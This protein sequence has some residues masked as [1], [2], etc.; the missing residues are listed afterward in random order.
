MKFIIVLLLVA[1]VAYA[2]DGEINGSIMT[3][4]GIYRII[5]TITPASG[6]N[7]L[8]IVEDVAALEN[9]EK[10][11]E[12]LASLLMSA[13]EETLLLKE[14][15]KLLDTAKGQIAEAM[16]GFELRQ[17]LL[18]EMKQ[19]KSEELKHAQAQANK[20]LLP[21]WM[22][23]A[24]LLAFALMMATPLWRKLIYSSG[25]E[26]KNAS[27]TPVDDDAKFSGNSE[28]SERHSAP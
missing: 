24:L 7:V 25:K 4:E 22:F 21:P 11:S 17:S 8:Y 28:V 15:M 16:A 5:N 19:A 13:K 2:H 9:A 18:E 23:Y 27:S 1:S 20:I 6:G 26:K 14:S 10:A 3:R 12:N